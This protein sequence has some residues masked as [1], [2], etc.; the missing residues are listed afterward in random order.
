MSQEFAVEW[1]QLVELRIRHTRV[2]S[3]SLKNKGASTE[4]VNTA[5]SWATGEAAEVGPPAGSSRKLKLSE[6]VHTSAGQQLPTSA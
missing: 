6:V 4:V 3:S 2:S 5:S 1:G